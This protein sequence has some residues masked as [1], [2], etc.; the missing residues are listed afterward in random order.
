MK[1]YKIRYGKYKMFYLSYYYNQEKMF[2]ITSCNF[3]DAKKK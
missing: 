2:K 3:Y 1:I